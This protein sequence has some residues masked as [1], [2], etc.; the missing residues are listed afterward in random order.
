M[1]R[2]FRYDILFEP[3]AIGPVKARNRFYQVPH[4]SGVKSQIQPDHLV[5]L[6]IQE[7]QGDLNDAATNTRRSTMP[8]ESGH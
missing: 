5:I 1:K 6:R 2:D 3:I 8:R 7:G 4:C